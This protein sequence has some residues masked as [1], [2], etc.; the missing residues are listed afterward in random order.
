MSAHYWS[1]CSAT[2]GTYLDC[3]IASQINQTF[4]VAIQNPALQT[5]YY[6]K[7]KVPHTK[8]SVQA[9]NPTAK[10]FQTVNSTVICHS[11]AFENGYKIQD[12]DLF[13]ENKI[14]PK[15]LSWL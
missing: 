10:K 5:V 2:N 12:C 8:Y 3:P 9:W 15:G 11:N 4:V 14:D 13:V 7:I 1:Q 6:Q